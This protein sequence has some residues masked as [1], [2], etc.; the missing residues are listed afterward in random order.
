MYSAKRQFRLFRS[1]ALMYSWRQPSAGPSTRAYAMS[2]D[3][4][5]LNGIL[6]NAIASG[7]DRGPYVTRDGGTTWSQNTT[8]MAF[9]TG[10]G[11][12]AC[13][14]ARSSPNI[15][16]CGNNGGGLG[17]LYKSTDYGTTWT[18]LTT[19][20]QLNWTGL[21]CNSS[22]SIVT[23]AAAGA[24][25]YKSTD[26][27]TTWATLSISNAQ[28]GPLC[29]SENGNVIATATTNGSRINVSTNGGTSFTSVTASTLAA[30]TGLSCSADGSIIF[31]CAASPTTAC[32]ISTDSGATWRTG[33][34]P[35]G[36][37][38]NQGY[39]RTACSLDGKR[40]LVTE[41]QSAVGG[42]IWMSQDRGVSWSD[43]AINNSNNWEGIAFSS[44][45]KTIL[46]GT[47]AV[48]KPWVGIGV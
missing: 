45:G 12:F 30:W 7:S 38:N 8:G 19:A 21:V 48:S 18:E 24:G 3:D 13:A 15:M 36:R 46:A 17:Y 6:A 28:W 27:G 32:V 42:Y 47:A 35:S 20:G 34:N 26:G 40:L 1:P 31:G 5:G 22:G 23:A 44:N 41:G 33:I 25:L 43:L 9:P 14:V 2:I 39:R 29:M 16:Y 37:T 4:T 11:T 10:V